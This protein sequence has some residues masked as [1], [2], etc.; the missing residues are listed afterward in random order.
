MKR[1]NLKKN[2]DIEQYIYAPSGSNK[3]TQTL[4]WMQ[5]KNL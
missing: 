3:S 2:I 4:N 1:L 5:D